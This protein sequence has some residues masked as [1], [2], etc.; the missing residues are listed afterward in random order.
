ML[1]NLIRFRY[2]RL[3]PDE[4]ENT[5]DEDIVESDLE[6]IVPADVCM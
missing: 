6:T 5:T 1:R 2:N 4:L 3:L